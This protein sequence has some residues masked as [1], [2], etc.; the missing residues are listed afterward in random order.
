MAPLSIHESANR[1]KIDRRGEMSNWLEL[2]DTQS[3]MYWIRAVKEKAL[4]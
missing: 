2:Y 1:L 4:S 3:F